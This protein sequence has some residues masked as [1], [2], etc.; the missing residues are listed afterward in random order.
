MRLPGGHESH[1]L[2]DT[3]PMLDE[4]SPEFKALVSSMKARGY[5]RDEPVLRV[6]TRQDGTP[7]KSLKSNTPL[8]RLV[9]D[10]RNRVV[11]GDRAGVK[12]LFRD[13]L[14]LEDG[15]AEGL[16]KLVDVVFGKNLARRNLNDDQRAMIAARLASLTPG[17]P[18]GGRPGTAAPKGT[19]PPGGITQEEAASRLNV[20]VRSLQRA[21]EVQ[22]NAIPEVKSAVERG[23]LPV[24][25]G[26][27]LSRRPIAIQKKVAK[28]VEID[29]G[30]GIRPGLVRTM[31]RQ[32]ER[33][34]LAKKIEAEPPPLITG[35]FRVIVADVPW[36]YE[37]RT[38][39]P[40]QRGQMDYPPMTIEEMC[41]L[42]V[43]GL[44]HPEGC[45]LWFWITNPFLLEGAHVPI[46][47]AW[48]FR[49]RSII[50]WDKVAPSPGNTLFNQTEHVILATVGSPPLTITNETTFFR[51]QRR[52]HSRKPERFYEIVDEVTK[53]SKVELFSRTPRAGYAAWG[54][55]TGKFQ[56]PK[57]T[58]LRA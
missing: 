24:A 46:L 12:V 3:L 15:T 16:G 31:V 8:K 57:Q 58:R 52:E 1:P 33:K 54:A 40:S 49:A 55:E 51:E 41:A 34:E 13:H 26:A 47:A 6:V 28:R 22:E 36:P 20:S 5:D 11:A 14:I 38:D 21:K 42:D 50:T 53:G 18:A 7:A 29:S 9:L 44:I 27:E 25:S 48:G 35:P 56:A 23:K 45:A 10:G 37:T 30:K 43:K 17:R 4:G 39:D 32:E 19:P 2:A